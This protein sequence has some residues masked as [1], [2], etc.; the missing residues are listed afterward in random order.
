M[1]AFGKN[2]WPYYDGIPDRHPYRILPDDVQVTISIN[3]FISRADVVRAVHLGMVKACEPLLRD[4]PPDADLSTFDSDLAI[5]EQLLNAA[6]AEPQ[7]L[8]ARAAKV[9]HRKRPG[10]IPMLDSVMV[11]AYAQALGQLQ[12]ARHAVEDKKRAGSAAVIV[13]AAFRSDLGSIADRL[14]PLH[15]LLLEKGTPMTPVRLLEVA[16]W[17]ANETRG[18]YRAGA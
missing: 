17:M 16:V 5:A 18:Y 15:G 12:L 4:I 2:E 7:I 10:Y 6:C 9:L 13:M 14:E 8:L 1:I 11:A 3:S